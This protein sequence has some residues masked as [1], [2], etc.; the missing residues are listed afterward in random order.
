MKAQK[1]AKWTP[2]GL[3]TTTTPT[4]TLKARQTTS[5]CKIENV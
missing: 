5:D 4:T 2:I 3:T 1:G